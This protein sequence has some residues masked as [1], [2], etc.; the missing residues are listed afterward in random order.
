MSK[1]PSKPQRGDKALQAIYNSVC[2]I[3]D[4][5]PTL[6]VRGDNKTISVSHSSVGTTIHANK[7]FSVTEGGGKTYSAGS[8]LSLS[9][10]EFNVNVDNTTIKITPNNALCCCV[11]GTGGESDHFY[12]YNCPDCS[13]WFYSEEISN[14]P[15]VATS[16]V[17]INPGWL[18]GDAECKAGFEAFQRA[19]LLAMS[20]D[21]RNVVVATGLDPDNNVTGIK[22]IG[23]E[24]VSTWYSNDY[25]YPSIWVNPN[26]LS[27]GTSCQAGYNAITATVN[28]YLTGL[29]GEGDTLKKTN[30]GLS[31]EQDNNDGGSGGDDYVFKYA[32]AFDTLIFASNSGS[33]YNSE[34]EDEIG[35][36]YIYVNDAWLAGDTPCKAG[37]MAIES[38][39]IRAMSGDS[40]TT[41]VSNSDED[42]KGIGSQSVSTYM[43]EIW[44]NPAWLS[45]G[46]NCQAGYQGITGAVAK[47]L[48]SLTVAETGGNTLKKDGSN[49]FGW[50]KDNAGSV[51]DNDHVFKYADPFSS[52]I[53]ASNSGSVYNSDESKIGEN[54]VYINVDW[55]AGNTECQAGY[56]AIC[57]AVYKYLTG[58]STY[59]ATSS[60]L[61]I[62][63]TN[64]TLYWGESSDIPAPIANTVL[65][66]DSSKQMAWTT[67][68][69][70]PP[71]PG[72][73]N[74]VFKYDD[75]FSSLIF[76]TN[77]ADDYDSD[78]E[79]ITANHI[80]VNS[81]WIAGNTE[82]KEGLYAV[83]AAM[84]KSLN[85]L[86][87][88]ATSCT[89]KI[90]N[91][92]SALYWGED[93]SGDSTPST[94]FDLLEQG[95][96]IK[97]TKL[98]NGK[99]QISG[100]AGGSSPTPTPGGGIAW[101][102]YEYLC[103]GA[104]EVYTQQW[105]TTSNGGHLRISNK[106]GSCAGVYIDSTRGAMQNYIGLGWN[107]TWILPIPPGSS[108]YITFDPNTSECYFD[109]AGSAGEPNL[110][111]QPFAPDNNALD[112][113]KSYATS[114]NNEKSNAY[115]AYDSAS[116]RANWNEEN[117]NYWYDEPE[118][119][120][121]EDKQWY[122]N[123][124]NEAVS[125]AT[126]AATASGLA[127][128]A[129]AAASALYNT[130]TS[131]YDGNF[132]TACL[133]YVEQ[134]TGY[135][136]DAL[137]YAQWAVEA[138]ARAKHYLDLA[139]PS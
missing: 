121:K 99:T 112:I 96:N 88:D 105:Y 43:N 137:N 92:T 74:K 108:F 79:D 134:A 34:D 26:W 40:T 85:A 44:V 116:D 57:S 3:I 23:S 124:W 90:D 128:G 101:P 16:W 38:A 8:G 114:A 87:H 7:N 81:D 24:S 42:V 107:N 15:N 104:S 28:K 68:N 48:N 52:L 117:Y 63:P 100:A 36:N 83:S 76:A 33:V 138:A 35:S 130:L 56:D 59:D 11:Q 22:A 110:T 126:D 119:N 122:T 5:L 13:L 91:A 78:E 84:V 71:T 120:D 55:L 10:N 62:N 9:G 39:I 25:P 45:G 47:Y 66:A 80:Y 41:V 54:N 82:C 72:D 65:S 50:Y 61:K 70:P 102:K 51:G 4:Y 53:F 129:A 67:L 18:Y 75:P 103:S 19:L 21:Y 69:I 37:F 30:N 93:L 29:T 136:Q 123:N 73:G 49:G 31:W 12:Y 2:Q 14:Y 27:G 86:P 46:T 135:A 77:D 125:Y 1:F 98:A 20:G 58:I 131:T 106:G 111:P 94:V 139:Y 97:L 132:L 6:E 118:Y 115:D 17:G 133:Q 127:S 64:N 60:T 89:L 113:L 109:N 95:P 32:A